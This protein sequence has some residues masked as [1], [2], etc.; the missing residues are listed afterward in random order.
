MFEIVYFW[1]MRITND[2]SRVSCYNLKSKNVVTYSWLIDYSSSEFHQ[3]LLLNVF[4]YL[5]INRVLASNCWA[6]T[7]VV[8]FTQPYLCVFISDEY[9]IHFDIWWIKNTFK[10]KYE[11]KMNSWIM[12]WLNCVVSIYNYYTWISSHD[13]WNLWMILLRLISFHRVVERKHEVTHD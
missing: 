7:R 8:N 2:L 3:A 12:K 6:I 4:L 9:K 10:W 11:M 5:M 13:L 1:K